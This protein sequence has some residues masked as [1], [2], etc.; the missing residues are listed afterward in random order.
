MNIQW[1]NVADYA[2]P[3]GLTCRKGDGLAKVISRFRRT[4]HTHL[5]WALSHRGRVKTLFCPA[6]KNWKG[7]RFTVRAKVDRDLRRFQVRQCWPWAYDIAPV[8]FK[9][10][11]AF[12]GSDPVQTWMG[13]ASLTSYASCP[14]WWAI[15]PGREHEWEPTRQGLPANQDGTWFAKHRG[16]PMSH[17]IPNRRLLYWTC[18]YIHPDIAEWSLRQGCKL[19]VSHAQKY[20]QPQYWQSRMRGHYT[21]YPFRQWPGH[22]KIAVYEDGLT[23]LST[24]NGAKRPSHDD[25]SLAISGSFRME[26]ILSG[27]WSKWPQFFDHSNRMAMASP[28]AQVANQCGNESASDYWDRIGFAPPAPPHHAPDDF[29]DL[30]DLDSIDMLDLSDLDQ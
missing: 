26:R 27:V 25:V 21:R 5:D 30:S 8:H 2:I 15:A 17:L 19:S 4:D 18:F 11:C 22:A 12:G 9:S 10:A 7:G 14:E 23:V 24:M 16:I 1:Y 28:L 13:T 29:I 20:R 6:A 3:H